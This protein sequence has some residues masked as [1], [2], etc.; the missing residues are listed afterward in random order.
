[1]MTQHRRT[2]RSEITTTTATTAKTT[3]TARSKQETANDERRGDG[4]DKTGVRSVRA[5][6]KG[7]RTQ[8]RRAKL[9][10]TRARS[11]ASLDG[12]WINGLDV[13]NNRPHP[14]APSSQRE[15][16][17]PDPAATTSS[18]ISSKCC[19]CSV[20]FYYFFFLSFTSAHIQA[21]QDFMHQANE[22]RCA[23]L[24]MSMVFDSSRLLL[25]FVLC[26]R[27]PT[28]V[29]SPYPITNRHSFSYLPLVSD[30]MKP[31]KE[32]N[33]ILDSIAVSSF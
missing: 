14:I 11:V 2:M 25:C 20:Y 31:W 9:R 21:F 29:V 8:R 27:F 15:T 13:D 32:K 5:C 10:N 26:R 7:P 22:R 12:R 24:L 30:Q 16:M 17:P 18:L 33:E 1:M 28:V 23:F 3:E 4:R 6:A 19:Q